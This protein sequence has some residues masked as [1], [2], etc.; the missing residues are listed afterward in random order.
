VIHDRLAPRTL[1]VAI[2]QLQIDYI[3]IGSETARAY[4]FQPQDS[5]M[6]L[7]WVEKNGEGE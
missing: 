4:V 1:L 5:N 6:T 3:R 7:V 2:A